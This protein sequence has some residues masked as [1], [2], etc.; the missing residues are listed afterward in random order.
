MAF[1]PVPDTA[2]LTWFFEGVSGGTLTGCEA[3]M[4]VYVR[5]EAAPDPWLAPQLA[6]LAAYGRDWYD[7]GKNAGT[8]FKTSV[9]AQWVLRRVVA[10]DL[11]VAGGAASIL[12][13][14]LVGTKAGDPVPPSVPMWC[15]FTCASG[16]PPKD[17]GTF[18]PVGTETDLDGTFFSGTFVG[19][20]QQQI[21][22]F[23]ADLNDPLSGGFVSW[24]HV[25]PSKYASTNDNVKNAREALRQAIAA[26]RRATALTNTVEVVEC[27]ELVGSQRDRRAD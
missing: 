24:A 8:A 3:Q 14:N 1:Q 7:L 25:V 11:Q 16:A 27:R 17:G 2:S 22:D 15:K 19:V 23:R 6:L 13:P 12:Q 5:D 21:E 9:S 20:V 26:T 10:R 18:L 4:Q